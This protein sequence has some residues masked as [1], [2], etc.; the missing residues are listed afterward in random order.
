MHRA[1]RFPVL[2]SALLLFCFSCG[3][4]PSKKHPEKKDSPKLP[5]VRTAEVLYKADTLTCHGFIAYD[6]KRG[7]KL[8]IVVIVHE[9]W[10]LN[11]YIRNRARQMAELGYFA[12]A[13]DM[14]GDNRVAANPAEA[15]ALAK[16]YYINPY[17]I[18]NRLAAAV[19]KAETFSQADS[20]R[21]GA[22][23]YC[24]G[25]FVVLNAAKMGLPLKGTVSFHGDLSGPAPRRGAING[26][27]LI[28]QGG[29]DQLVPEKQRTAFRKTMDSAE[30]KYLFMTYPGASHAFTNPSATQ[31]GQQFHLPV[32][33]NPGAD[34]ASWVDMKNFFSSTLR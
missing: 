18:R 1:S 34:S 28:C 23:G 33:Y 17:I 6:R 16:P 5:T 13:A 7:G 19:A 20:T 21:V 3:R 25:G 30:V 11:D 26:E 8:P 12:I 4:T 22:M 15:L 32:A 10:G 31:I 14:Y 24:F 27:M 2:A 29:S 9:W